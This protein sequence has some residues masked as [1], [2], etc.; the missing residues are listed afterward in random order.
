MILSYYKY[1]FQTNKKNLLTL[2]FLL[3]LSVLAI[4]CSERRSPD[5]SDVEITDERVFPV[6]VTKPAIHDLNYEVE[7]IGSFLAEEDVVIGAE[8]A[9][10]IKKIH[11]EEGSIVEK[12]QLLIEID[13]RTYALEVNETE[14]LLRESIARL[15][16][17]RSTLNRMTSLFEE[18]IIGQHDFDEATTQV[19]L[20]RASVERLESSLLRSKKALNDTKVRSPIDGII[21]QKLVSTGEYVKVGS[22]LVNILEINP[23][24]LSFTLPEVNS[25]KINTDQ[26]V[27]VKTRAYPDKEYEGKIYFISPE[28]D[29]DSRSFEVKA[30]V[31]NHEHRLKPGM[32]VDV[33]VLIEKRRALVVP[34]NA[35]VVR[36]GSVVV[37]VVEKDR[38]V[39]KKVITG[40]RFNGKVEIRQ[41]LSPD[42]IVVVYGLSEITEGSL[43]RIAE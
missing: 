27:S 14:A 20:Y 35:V 29:T 41:G 25:G 7:A 1:L 19:A 13:D 24:K 11:I 31:E 9:G 23:L 18:G 16:N 8:A 12:G 6:D 21:N 33:K 3:L 34:E 17:A 30:R 40:I 26:T 43:V 22:E 42:D 4:A 10:S 32:F 5:E 28:V 36:E 37:M 15:E 2:L 38:V 39:Y